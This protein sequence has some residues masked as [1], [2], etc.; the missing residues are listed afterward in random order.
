MK[1]SRDGKVVATYSLMSIPKYYDSQEYNNSRSIHL[2]VGP[3]GE[4][5]M[6]VAVPTKQRETKQTASIVAF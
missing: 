5:L 3:R 4:F 6:I 2:A 1:V